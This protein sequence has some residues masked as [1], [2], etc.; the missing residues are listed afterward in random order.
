M[1]HPR[2]LWN[3]VTRRATVSA[4]SEAGG[5]SAVNAATPTTFDRWRPGSLDASWEMVFDATETVS[6][7][8]IEAHTIG[9]TG[10]GVRPQEWNGS[11]WQ[12]I[13]TERLPVDDSPI[14]FLFSA[15]DIDRIRLRLTGA[16]APEVGVVYVCEALEMPRKSYQEVQSPIDMALV[17]EFYTNQSSGGQYLGRS[18]RRQKNENRFPVANLRE[19]WVR[20]SFMPFALDAR[21]H[22]FFLLERPESIPTALSYRWMQDDIRP[23]RMGVLDLMQVTL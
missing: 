15:R 5:Y 18:V 11:G 7:V 3:S 6:A 17:T 2:I 21:E 12:N 14:V 9:S 4:S 16:T 19:D 10:C 8:A 20:S 23:Q 1:D 13:M 22:P